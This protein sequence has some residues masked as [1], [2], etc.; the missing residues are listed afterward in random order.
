MM[1]LS[2]TLRRKTDPKTG[3][4]TLCEPAHATCA[5]TF[6]KSHYVGKFT[7]GHRFVRA[8][9]VEMHMDRAQEA[10]R[11]EISRENTGR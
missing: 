6:H 4:H 11:A 2:M 5:W 10:F 8:C 1:M 7:R 9:A 3:K